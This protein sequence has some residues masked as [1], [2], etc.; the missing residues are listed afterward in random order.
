MEPGTY[1]PTE[2]F[3]ILKYLP[4]RWNPTKRHAEECHRIW[5]A[6][7][8]EARRRVEKRRLQGDHRDSLFDKLV[9]SDVKP[10]VPLTEVQENGFAMT[11]YLGAGDTTSSAMLTNILFLAAHPAVQEKARSELDRVCGAERMPEWADFDALPY[12]NCII[13]EG[14]RIRAV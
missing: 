8:S 14:L 2:H 7:G 1:V 12:I 6:H 4:D 5:I 13:K 11:V 10:D 9:G 3:P